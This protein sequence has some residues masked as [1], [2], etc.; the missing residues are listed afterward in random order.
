LKDNLGCLDF[1]LTTGQ[2]E[3]LNEA[4]P[5]DLGFP[6]SFLASNHVRGLI[7]GKTFPQIISDRR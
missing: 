6:H 2:I 7:F 1:A 5:I 3:R 4:S